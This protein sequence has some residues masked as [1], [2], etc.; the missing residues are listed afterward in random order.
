VLNN[1]DQFYSLR[2]LSVSVVG[3]LLSLSIIGEHTRPVL[4]KQLEQVPT[5]TA[6]VGTNQDI[7]GTTLLTQLRQVRE[8]RNELWAATEYNKYQETAT[9][10]VAL[11]STQKSVK[12]R[13][14][15]PRAIFPQQD[16]VYLY[17]QSPQ[18]NQLGQ[19]YIIFEKRQGR[20]KG[21]LYMPSSE[22]SCFQGTLD[23]SGELAMTVK[24]L[25]DAGGITE[26]ATSNRLPRN[27]FD[28]DVPSTYA[29]SVTL[30]NYHQIK[31]VGAND[32]RIL[33]MCK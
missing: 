13:G 26:V 19:G 25:P 3:L 1:I 22:F 16:G 2:K 7:A 32:R 27:I 9:Q 5:S 24:A 14:T 10:T 20:V 8:Q 11:V 31:P 15:A 29:Y 21:A 6:L 28:D 23:K 17:G 30:Q 33:Q 4:S 18:A 12:G